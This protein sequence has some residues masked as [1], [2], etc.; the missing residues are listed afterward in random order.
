[1]AREVL[2]REPREAL[3][4]LDVDDDDFGIGLHRL[5]M[6]LGPVAHEA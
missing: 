1:V 4:I 3:V 2:H 6:S 5:S